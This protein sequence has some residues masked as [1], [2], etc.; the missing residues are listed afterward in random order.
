MQ[1]HT[2]QVHIDLFV[3]WHVKDTQLGM[4][5]AK[6]RISYSLSREQIVIFA[7]REQIVIFTIFPQL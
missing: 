7:S 4:Y 3:V 2:E 6:L 5:E 1:C